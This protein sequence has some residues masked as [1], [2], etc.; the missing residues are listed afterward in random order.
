MTEP[1]QRVGRTTEIGQRKGYRDRL[2]QGHSEGAKREPD[3]E[4]DQVDISEEARSRAEG[5]YKKSILEHVE[6]S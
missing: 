1:V 3:Q 4:D 6:D 2:H 5:R